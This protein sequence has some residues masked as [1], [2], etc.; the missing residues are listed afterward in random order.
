MILT[1]LQFIPDLSS[2]W[3]TAYTGFII[4]AAGMVGGWLLS[5][6]AR[7]L[8]GREYTGR[9]LGGML[10]AFV[11]F[12]GLGMGL[13]STWQTQKYPI[14]TVDTTTRTVTFGSERSDLSDIAA[15]RT[16]SAGRVSLVTGEDRAGTQAK[17][18][19]V[20]TRDGKTRAFPEA[21]YDIRKLQYALRGGEE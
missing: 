15:T 16:V 14:I 7:D 1:I 8:R 3:S 12:L 17:I 20:E 19:L 10:L 13:F 21:N 4:A 18:L 11:G 5:R 6:S 2:E 9:Q